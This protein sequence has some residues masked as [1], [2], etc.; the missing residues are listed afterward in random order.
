MQVFAIISTS[1]HGLLSTTFAVYLYG[2]LALSSGML[3]TNKL[4]FSQTQVSQKLLIFCILW[5]CF[6]LLLSLA[7]SDEYTGIKIVLLITSCLITV[8]CVEANYMARATNNVIILIAVISLVT[9]VA[10]NVF[11]LT[12]T[13][14]GFTNVNGVEYTGFWWNYVHTNFLKFRNIGVFWEPGLY[15]NW[16]FLS[17][18]L[19]AYG[20]DRRAHIFHV[21]LI[22]TMITTFSF[23][24]WC[25]LFIYFLT[26]NNSSK[27]R[28]ILALLAS[29]IFSIYFNEILMTGIEDRLF[30][31]KM[32]TTSRLDSYAE[33]IRLIANNPIIGVG[34]N[35]VIESF[36]AKVITTTAGTPFAI[37]ASFG[38]FSS[39]VFYP[40]FRALTFP[41]F[42][43]LLLIALCIYLI[44]D[45]QMF[46]SVFILLIL[47]S[48]Q[49]SRS[50]R[51]H[52]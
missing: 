24:G 6:I 39:I 12:I 43:F 34:Y 7:H 27:L 49:I 20:L 17:L 36:S 11:N 40:L 32:S 4:L 18:M 23:A 52:V 38:I 28:F 9:Y 26:V 10:N 14:S 1:G 29:A 51:Q 30:S 47:Y 21:I 41:N 42:H 5:S 50:A 35:G 44:K 15:A 37:V 8:I 3:L 33:L 46:F 48:H 25:Y 13:S 22:L 16:L 2:I 31:G 19:M 45:N